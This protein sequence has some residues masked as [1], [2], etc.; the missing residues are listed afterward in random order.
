MRD[1]TAA[2]RASIPYTR[3]VSDV[4][5]DVFGEG[6]FIGKGIYDVDA[7]EQALG[8]RFPENRILS[9][10]LLEG[11]YARA[12][13][14][15]DVQLYEDYPARY[16]ADVSRRHRWIRGDWQLAGWLLAAR[17]RHA[18][19]A[20]AGAASGKN[21]LS[22][23]S[24]WKLIDNLRRSLVPAALTL[25]LLLGWTLLSPAWLWTV[26]V[27]GILLIPALCA[28]I[29]DLFRKPEEVLLR[30]HLAAV[31]RSAVAALAA[32]G[33]RAR[34]PALRGVLQPG[35][36][37]A[38]GLA[39]AGHAQTAARMESVERGGSRVGRARPQRP[40]RL[41]PGDVG[42]A[43]HRRCGGDPS[44]RHRRRRCWRWR[45]RSCCCGSPR[46]VVAWW[47]S[48]PLARRKAT[49]T[50]S[51]RSSCARWRAGPG[52]SSTPSSARK[53]TGCRPTTIRST[54]SP[55][56]RIA[57]RRPT[58]GWRC[59][60]ICPPTTSAT[61]RPDNS[62]ER[63]ANTLRTMDGLERH[64]G[65]FYNWYDTQ[66]L[67]PLPPLYVSTVDSGNLAGHLLTL[68]AGLLALADDR[69]LG[70]AAVRRPERHAADSRG[71]GGRGGPRWLPVR[72]PSF[73]NELGVRVRCP[74]GHARGGA[75]VPRAA[76]QPV[77]PSSSP[78]SPAAST[79]PQA[80]KRAHGRRRCRNA[81][82]AGRT[83]A[84]AVGRRRSSPASAADGAATEPARLALDASCRIG[85]IER[86]D[87][88]RLAP[89]WR[90]RAGS[91]RA[92]DRMAAIERLAQQSG[93]LARHG[94]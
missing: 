51:R 46:P 36:H 8:G 28:S 52:R 35:C 60:R 74:A 23:L 33:V 91:A 43:G 64:R 34:L 26:A 53:T 66:T 9:H 92:R 93:E 78:R 1:C 67:Q 16:S 41:F 59:W 56:S 32:G 30:Q 10:D 94:V 90:Q 21:P 73:G 49:L 75:R 79:L 68:R 69:I 5:Q 57:P 29:L 89:N 31:A 14:L 25:L 45:G 84:C 83:D 55:R 86:D 37:R 42:R 70:G 77:P 19:Q 61:S 27:L 22:A 39:D 62:L 72:W 63:T 6:S 87:A 76:G 44:G 71:R 18:A 3:A 54:A 20:R 48:R 82:G 58:W 40:R 2:S 38:H 88:R 81:G 15:S 12:G 13:L 11:C 4:Y 85:S 47:I 80:T 17:A 50:P 7:F 24:Q 65:H